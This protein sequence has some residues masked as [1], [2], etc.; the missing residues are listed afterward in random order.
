MR[1]PRE[2]PK[3]L[4]V[5]R[6]MTEPKDGQ[7][8]RDLSKLFHRADEVSLEKY[9][10]WDELWVREPP[11]GLSREEWWFLFKL[12]RQ[13]LKQNIPLM[14]KSGALMTLVMSPTILQN[15]H[16]I[17]MRA[18]GQIRMPEP[19]TNPDTKD[20]YYVSSLVEEAITSSQ[21][22]GATTTRRVAKEMLQT[23]RAP[24]DRSER[25]ILNNFLTMRKI[26]AL[27]NQPLT[28]DLILEIHRRVTHDTL[29]DPT[30]AGRFRRD[31][32]PV[33]VYDNTNNT[34][35]HD[36]PPSSELEGRIKG[37]CDFA[38]REEP[39]VHPV[40]RSI[41]LHFMLGY[42]HPFV[43]GNGRTARALFYWSMLRHGY[44]LAEFI[45]ISQIVLKA[46]A[47]YA[48]SFL[49]TET[50]E[51][52][53]T[54]FILYHL[55]IVMRAL[56]SLHEYIAR[57]AQEIQQFE[58]ELQGT[59]VLNHRQRA[60]IRHAMRHPGKF[61]TVKGH[62][63]SH[64]VSYESARSD[65][66]DLAKRDLLEAKREGGGSGNRWMFLAKPQLTGRLAAMGNRA[67]GGSLILS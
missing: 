48:R 26:G 40:I 15:L 45:S 22:E 66:L 62:R 53:L 61:Y 59:A 23:G 49:H 20:A 21:L 14:D 27:K 51:A 32:E 12:Q 46:P 39:F 50:D 42:D 8:T 33:G 11:T 43:D 30:A 44:W 13:S 56:A 1:K 2:A 9:L 41:V 55:K 10:H 54:Y 38:N 18:G 34:L 64:N 5:L 63:T 65:L 4:D 57:K 67:S 24:Q 52:D 25:M 31:D 47:K 3:F 17:D 6:Q 29:D 7:P 28:R 35:M 16:E 19:V 60:L 37:M 36:P 58:K